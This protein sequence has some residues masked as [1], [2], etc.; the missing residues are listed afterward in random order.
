MPKLSQFA[1]NLELEVGGQWVD[2]DDQIPAGTG[3]RLLLARAGNPRY[4]EMLRREREPILD[5]IRTKKVD[6]SALEAVT[7]KCLAHTVFLGWANVTD[8]DGKE[9][10]YTPEL[11]IMVLSEPQYRDLAAFI[12]DFASDREN[13][14]KKREEGSL[15][16]SVPSSSG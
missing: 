14:R 8:E 4:Q 3:I 11:G 5:Q 9:L 10:V 13:F 15:G 1:S 16:N 2:Y 7:R 12:R 6:A